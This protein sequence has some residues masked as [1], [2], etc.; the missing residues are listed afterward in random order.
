MG[1]TFSGSGDTENHS[2]LTCTATSI[3]GVNGT[4]LPLSVS[5]IIRVTE[6]LYGLFSLLVGSFLNFLVMFVIAKS[7]KLRIATFSI[8]FQ[9]SLNNFISGI[10]IGFTLIINHVA[11]HW[12]FGY[13]G[14]VMNG[15]IH[16][17]L[18]NLRGFLIFIFALDLFFFVFT[19]LYYKQYSL[20]VVT[21]L[22]VLAWC[23]A[24]ALSLSI[25]PGLLDCYKLSEPVLLCFYSPRCKGCQIFQHIYLLLAYTPLIIPIGILVAL[26]LKGRKFRRAQL[27]IGQ[28]KTVVQTQEWKALK[29]FIFLLVALS[30][31]SIISPA[32][33]IIAGSFFQGTLHSLIVVFSS[34]MLSALIFTDPII[35]LR[36]KKVQEVL[37]EMKKNV[38]NKFFKNCKPH[39]KKRTNITLVEMNKQ[40]QLKNL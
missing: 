3:E 21:I 14:C 11:G 9:L 4:D 37:M 36:N 26:Y 39:T 31:V 7:E 19:P 24:A 6:I 18:G 22:C 27:R 13:E 20:R 40:N 30:L 28:S 5:V 23:L 12:I 10:S 16:F 38:S 32:L 35:I 1:I 25:I 15:F 34:N 8:A 2:E 33:F 17:T 29:T